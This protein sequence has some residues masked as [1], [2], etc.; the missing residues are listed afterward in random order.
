[1]LDSPCIEIIHGKLGWLIL[2][3]NL[4][5]IYLVKHYYVYFYEGG[6][7]KNDINI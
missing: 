5:L 2:Y 7:F 6:F 1:M 3:A 4:G